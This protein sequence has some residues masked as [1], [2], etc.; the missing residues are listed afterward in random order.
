MLTTLTPYL[1][2]S[3]GYKNTALHFAAREGHAKAVA[4]LLSYNADILLNK[5]QASFL[6]IALH[7]KRK[8]VVL[9]TI[10]SKR[11]AGVFLSS[12]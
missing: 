8:E 7:N 5:K 4:M 3:F 2:V 12:L 9:T 10:R 11:Y 1:Y 6:H